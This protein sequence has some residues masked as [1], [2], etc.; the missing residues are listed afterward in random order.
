[1][2]KFRGL[3]GEK[4]KLEFFLAVM[5]ELNTD[6]EKILDKLFAEAE[7]GNVLPTDQLNK[8]KEEAR[9]AMPIYPFVSDPE[10]LE[11]I[12]TL[13]DSLSEACGL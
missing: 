12:K 10:K 5:H 4:A 13:R 6:D 1:M 3:I 2:E 9:I 7:T 11:K 8:F